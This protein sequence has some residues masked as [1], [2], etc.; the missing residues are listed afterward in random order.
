M[1]EKPVSQSLDELLEMDILGSWLSLETE[2]RKEAVAQLVPRNPMPED[3]KTILARAHGAYVSSI[4]LFTLDKLDDVNNVQETFFT[5]M[6]SVIFFASD[7]SDGFFFVDTDGSLGQESG[8]A[9]SE[10]WPK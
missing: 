4:N 9:L 3:L 10:P 5:H 1:T 2:E 7:G 8:A 6:P